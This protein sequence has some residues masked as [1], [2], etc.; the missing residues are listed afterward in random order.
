[1]VSL[2]IKFTIEQIKPATVATVAITA[3]TANVL[4]REITLFL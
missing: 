2:Q 1:M 3:N 4:F